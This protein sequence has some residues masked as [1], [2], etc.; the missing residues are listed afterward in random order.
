[1]S[2]DPARHL[3]PV[4]AAEADLEAT[5]L[6]LNPASG[7]TKPFLDYTQTLRDQIA[8]LETDLAAWRTR[9][10][11]LKRDKEKE[12][13][14]HALF[15]E[16]KEVFDYW[17]LKCR[18]PRSVWSA[19]RFEQVR[20]FLEK[21]GADMCKLAV[22]GAAF[23]PKEK[24]RKNGTIERFDDFELIFRSP[25]KFESF[26]NRAPRERIAEVMQAQTSLDEAQADG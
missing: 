24:P 8:G 17:R 15:P 4:D 20:T 2:P 7:E 25:Q 3:R 23:A 9:H 26:C 1:M 10:A 11:N 12:A 19:D 14:N 22:D 21:H 13:R 18:H 5:L 6:V 16:A